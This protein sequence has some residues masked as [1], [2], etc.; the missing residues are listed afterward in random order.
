MRLP[1]QRAD[2]RIMNFRQIRPS[3]LYL[4]GCFVMTALFAVKTWAVSPEVVISQV[5]GGGGMT[6]APYNAD[7]VELHNRADY[8]VMLGSWS[9]QYAS[10]TGSHWSVHILLTGTLLAAGE[11][12][13]ISMQTGSNGEPLPPPDETGTLM[14]AS[15]NGKVAL[16]NHTTTLTG[17]CPSDPGII[18]FVGYGS[19]NCSETAPVSPLSST[20]AAIRL[21]GGCLDTDDNS[22]DF[23]AE[24]PTPRS[25]GIWN[26]CV[27]PPKP[28]LFEVQGGYIQLDSTGDTAPDAS[29]CAGPEH[30]GRMIVQAETEESLWICAESGWR[31]FLPVE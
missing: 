6:G 7:F 19:A 1:K 2:S 12:Y 8:A 17:T 29:E 4:L 26:L 15:T 30:Y 5:Y 14:L 28:T 16:V 22:F 20:L 18:D 10:S 23:S 27:F 25:S 11:F 21:D 9:I 3:V 31:V 13:L 24:L